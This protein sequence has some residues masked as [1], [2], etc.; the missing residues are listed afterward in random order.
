MYLQTRR[1]FIKSCCCV[2]AT[3]PLLI[4]M[5]VVINWSDS[6]IYVPVITMGLSKDVPESRMFADDIVLCGGKE[7]DMMECMDRGIKSLEDRD[8]G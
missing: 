6:L 3:I 4:M 8:E 7:V 1:H 2:V 5:C